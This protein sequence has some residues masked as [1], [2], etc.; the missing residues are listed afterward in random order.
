MRGGPR[1]LVNQAVCEFGSFPSRRHHQIRT[2]LTGGLPAVDCCQKETA[3]DAFFQRVP[4]PVLGFGCEGPLC[5]GPG[6]YD[7]FE[8]FSIVERH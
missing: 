8:H 3:D 6:L 7:A 1:V 5:H 2:T 4:F